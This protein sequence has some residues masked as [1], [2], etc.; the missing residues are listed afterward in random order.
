MPQASLDPQATRPLR[1]LPHQRSRLGALRGAEDGR[2]RRLLRRHGL[3]APTRH[4]RTP[5]AHAAVPRAGAP[6][7]GHLHGPHERERLARFSPPRDPLESP[8]VATGP[9]HPACPRW[10]TSSG[11]GTRLALTRGEAR[12]QRGRGQAARALASSGRLGPGVAPAGPV[13]RRRRQAT[14]GRP[15]RTWACSQAARS[16]VRADPPR[17]RGC[18]RHRGRPRGQGGHRIADGSRAHHLAQAVDPGLRDGTVARAARL[19]RPEPA[20]GGRPP[21][22]LTGRIPP[23]VMGG[24]RVRSCSWWLGPARHL[25]PH[26]RGLVPS[27]R[28]GR[29]TGTAP[30]SFWG[31]SRLHRTA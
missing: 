12:G 6:P 25:A 28:P 7:L 16:A 10:R 26:G 14:P 18:D 9:E 29:E 4:D 21:G 22:R 1:D 15:P 11:G 13:R 20:A 3:L 5:T 27:R 2:L 31:L 30:I 23:P 17:R 24:G 8:L 19:L